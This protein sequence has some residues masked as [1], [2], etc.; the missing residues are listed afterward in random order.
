MQKTISIT[1]GRKRLFQIAE[2]VQNPDTR[3]VF[4]DKG[5]SKIT[6]IASS[7]YDSILETLEVMR[8]FPNLKDDIAEGRK[9]FKEGK[10]TKLSDYLAK[11]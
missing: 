9:E 8:E 6:L 5:M 10:T 3:Y 2:E 7:E 11:K 4:T 1:E